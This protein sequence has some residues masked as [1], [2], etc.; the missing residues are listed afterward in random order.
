VAPGKGVTS[1]VRR[2]T[3]QARWR[4]LP[5]RAAPAQTSRECRR[6]QARCRRS[7]AGDHV[8]VGAILVEQRF[9]RIRTAG[10]RRH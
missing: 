5:P 9:G 6:R 3:K 8:T 10:Q 1:V 2:C 7:A 4:R